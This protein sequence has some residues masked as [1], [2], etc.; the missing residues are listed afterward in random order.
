[1]SENQPMASSGDLAGSMPLF[2]AETGS[3][4]SSSLLLPDFHQ[5]RLI[6]GR[7]GQ[8][9]TVHVYSADCRAGERLRVRML[10]PA[11]PL[12]GSVVPAF[13]VIAQ[14]LPY[15]ADIHKLPIDLP[16]G[17]SAV[18]APPPS[19]LILPLRDRVTGTRYYPGPVIDTHTL[20]SGRC[21]I[22]A[23][24]PHN[25]MGKYVL[26]TGYSWPW[27]F[28]YW[29]RL[30]WFWWQIRGWFGLT[31]AAA[32]AVAGLLLLGSIVAWRGSQG[33]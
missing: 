31:R 14:S 11:L 17:Y 6:Y 30:P 10:V 18:V 24:S 25:H 7:L 15:S 26:Q 32:Y 22:V 2:P 23:W 3:S 33:K 20:V 28:A 8:P 1:M 4:M 21:Y 9:G 19:Q 12:G 5:K 16:A 27:Q 13:A 29:L